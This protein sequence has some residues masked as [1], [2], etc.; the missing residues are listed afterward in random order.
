MNSRSSIAERTDSPPRSARVDAVRF[1]G[2][3][4][5]RGGRAVLHD[6]DASF[7]AGRVTGLFGPSG[8]G[9]STL[10]RAIAGVQS[11]VRGTVIVLGERPGSMA[12][13]GALGYMTQSPSV[14]EDLT[15]AE[16]VR[17][18]AAIHGG[19]IGDVLERV[20]LSSHANQ[21]VRNLSGGQRARVSLA[22][23]LV[24]GPRLLLLD[25][26]TVGLDPLLRR[27]LWHL[28]G[29]LANEGSALLVSSH[30]LD[31]ARHCDEV[32]LLREGR[33]V[34]QLTPLELSA[35]TGTEDMDEAFIRL[36]ER[37]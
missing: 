26:P 23:A 19:E 11:G 20:Q 33:V 9:K 31:E 21:L 13:R 34:A 29:E 14:Y 22:A 7:A 37:Q 6:V 17:Y 8:S 18:F 36:I 28:F 10:I 5:E 3:T 12:V 2:V 15:V 25:E 24:G 4:V 1:E 27:D 30:V 16:N 35:R 32:I